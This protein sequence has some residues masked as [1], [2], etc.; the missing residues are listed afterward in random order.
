MIFF[1]SEDT[2]ANRGAL[3]IRRAPKPF[4]KYNITLIPR[5]NALSKT[6][7]RMLFEHQLMRYVIAL[8]PFPAALIIWPHLALPISQAPLFMF[9]LIWV[10]E[11]RFLSIPKEERPNLIFPTEA[12]R[13][14]DTLQVRG[15]DALGRLAAGRGLREGELHLVIEQSELARVSPLTLI[16]VQTGG[17]KP[18]FL[19][20]SESEQADLTK[21][22]FDEAFSE[23]DLHI[24]ALSQESYLHDIVLDPT[25][26]SAHAR[27]AAMA[28]A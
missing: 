14:L 18:T 23:S 8:S 10:F 5:R 3:D 19:N 6:G 1:V 26:V 28:R 22:L 21:T 13:R 24:V 2:V 11:I 25:T 20:L 9:I 15:S 17:E 7:L 16:S 4:L 27:L 12:A